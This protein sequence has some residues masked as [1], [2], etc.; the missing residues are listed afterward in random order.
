MK[1]GSMGIHDDPGVQAV[2]VRLYFDA[3]LNREE[4][5]DKISAALQEAP[6]LYELTSAYE[7]KG[8]VPLEEPLA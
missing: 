4:L 6:Q 1:E 7:V 5:L 2:D 3:E 8:G